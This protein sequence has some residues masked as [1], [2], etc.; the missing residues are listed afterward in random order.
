MITHKPLCTTPPPGSRGR[1]AS[2]TCLRPSPLEPWRLVLLGC[3][4]A[5]AKARRPNCFT[6]ASAPASFPPAT[7]F[8]PASRC[9][10]HAQPAITAAL[11]YMGRGRARARQDRGRFGPGAGTDCLRCPGGFLLDG[12]PRTVAQAEAL[13]A[14]LAEMCMKLDAVVDYALPI[15]EVVSTAQRAADVPELQFCFSCDQPAAESPGASA[16]TAAATLCSVTTTAPSRSACGWPPTRRAPRRW[17]TTTED[18][19]VG[20]SRRPR[21][22]GADFPADTAPA[23]SV[24]HMPRIELANLNIFNSLS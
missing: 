9:P 10:K 7:N 19:P 4:W 14:M 6:I 8:A 23:E 3:A 18:G 1:P 24:R 15:E 12:F 5:S 13:A 17:P 20:R 22:A 16:T 11:E 21:L 2:T